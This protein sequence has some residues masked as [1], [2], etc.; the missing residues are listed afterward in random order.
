MVRLSTIKLS[1]QCRGYEKAIS[2]TVGYGGTHVMSCHV[3]S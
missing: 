2:M 1:I 3:M